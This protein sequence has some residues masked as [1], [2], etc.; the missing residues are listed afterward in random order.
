MMFTEVWA[1]TLNTVHLVAEGVVGQVL[2]PVRHGD[3]VV[4]MVGMVE[5]VAVADR[6]ARR[7]MAAGE[8]AAELLPI[9]PVAAAVVDQE[10]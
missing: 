8:V 9:L 10:S 1:C 2:V 3:T 5:P 7:I 6:T 4:D